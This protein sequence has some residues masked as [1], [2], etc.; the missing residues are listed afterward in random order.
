MSSA[1]A[2]LARSV[3]AFIMT[4]TC[5]GYSAFH[6]NRIESIVCDGTIPAPSVNVTLTSVFRVSS[7]PHAY[8]RPIYRELARDRG[9]ALLAAET[10]FDR[11]IEAVAKDDASK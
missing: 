3:P 7:D 10:R 4:W 6:M 8:L 9:F 1:A 11:L 2:R 5:R